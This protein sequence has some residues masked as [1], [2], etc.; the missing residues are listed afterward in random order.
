MKKLLVA[1]LLVALAT[2]AWCAGNKAKKLAGAPVCS[3]VLDF[4]DL[5]MNPY[6]TEGR[7][8]VI[9]WPMLAKEYLNRHTA[10]YAFAN[11][12]RVK[13]RI[14]FPGSAVSF[15]RGYVKALRPFRYETVMG[16]I[17]TVWW[18]K[19]ISYNEAFGDD[20]YRKAIALKKEAKQ[21]AIEE[22]EKKAKAKKEEAERLAE[23]ARKAE[24]EK[25]LKLQK[26][27]EL[28]QE[29]ARDK[30][31]ERL[32]KMTIPERMMEPIDYAK[33]YKE[34]DDHIT[35]YPPEETI[36]GYKL[37]RPRDKS[38]KVTCYNMKNHRYYIVNAYWKRCH[39]RPNK[40]S[41]NE[42]VL[43]CDN[44]QH[45]ELNGKEYRLN[46]Q[47]VP[48]KQDSVLNAVYNAI[49][50]D[51]EMKKGNVRPGSKERN[52]KYFGPKYIEDR[53]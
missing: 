38:V 7:C 42:M 6:D 14:D 31:Y 53:I 1:L 50:D 35:G 2:P 24:A 13:A 37:D 12:H 51:N 26:A 33:S 8:Y 22:A 44:G 45:I 9:V 47:V 19:A 40:S 25:A 23:S 43:K 52:K 48:V 11:E 10:L 17:N 29:R 20:D 4:N 46:N 41:L 30:E 16:S 49:L 28:E 36:F 5:A 27:Q 15:F 21:K 34:P 39:V 32:A 3:E 18:F